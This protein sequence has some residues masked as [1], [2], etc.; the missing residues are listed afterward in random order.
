MNALFEEKK[1]GE[2]V[3]NAWIEVGAKHLVTIA[4]TW[5]EH[6]GFFHHQW[7]RFDAKIAAAVA[8]ETNLP[9]VTAA[10]KFEALAAHD[11]FVE[12][13]GAFNTV[14]ASLMKIANDI[15]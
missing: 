14:A 1:K 4:C 2:Y 5:R 8:E 11:A 3:G 15:Q 6:L 7:P 12:T 13:S 10:N 9:F